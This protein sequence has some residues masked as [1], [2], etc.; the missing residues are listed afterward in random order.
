MK[1][2]YLIAVTLLFGLISFN[3]SYG[4]NITPERA[5][6][7]LSENL[8]ALNLS[9]EDLQN[10]EVRSA[11]TDKLSGVN[12]VYLQQY[13]QGLPVYN[14]LQVIAFKNNK[15]VSSTG[16]R[17]Y[18]IEEAAGAQKAAPALPAKEAVTLAAKAVKLPADIFN[19]QPLTV[20]RQSPDGRITE[21][22][23]STVMRENI[24][25]ELMWVPDDLGNV[26]LG[27]EIKL[28]PFSSS[29][30][31]LV[32][33]DATTGNI[34]G[35][36]NNTIYCNWDTPELIPGAAQKPDNLFLGLSVPSV[37]KLAPA[38]KTAPASAF[39]VNSAQYNVIPFPA[40]S[41]E[42]NGGTISVVTNPWTLAGPGND[43]TTLKWHN[44]GTTEY[45]ITRG[46]NVLARENINNDNNGQPATSSSALPDLSFNFP[47]NPNSSPTG[48][49]N[50]NLAITNL[51]YWNNIMH[52]LT[53][54][55]GFD[56]VAGN[57]QASNM[58]RGAGNPKA[59]ENDYVI[60][61]AQ[62]GSGTNNASFATGVDGVNPTMRMFLW[63]PSPYKTLHINAPS[64]IETDVFAIESNLS[65]NNKLEDV[66]PVTNNLVLYIDDTPEGKSLACA[67]PANA[68]QLNGRIAVIDRG[69]CAFTEKIKNAQNAGAIGVIVINTD[70]TGITMSGD[71]NSITIPAVA[72]L[73]SDGNVLKSIMASYTIN[74]TLKASQDLDG[75]L[76]NGIIAHE[77]AHGISVRLTGGQD[78]ISCLNNQEQMGEGWSDYYSIMITHDWANASVTDGNI[79][80]AVGTY[81]L[82]ENPEDGY[83]IRNYRYTTDMGENPWTYD[84]LEPAHASSPHVVGELWATTLWHMTWNMIEQEGI[85][86]TNLFDATAEGANS[87][88]L[89]LVTLGLKLQP[90]SPG[91]LDGRDAL[92]KADEILFD[93]KYSCAIWDAFAKRGMG[94]DAVQ[95]SSNSLGDQ[96]ADF[97]KPNG[98]LI[99]KTVDKITAP[100]NDILTYTFNIQAQCEPISGFK[101]VDTLAPNV[102]YVSG[103]T[104]NPGNRTVTLN[105]P[106]LNAG[107]SASLTLKVKI[108][109]GTYFVSTNL[110]SETIPTNSMPASLVATTSDETKNWAPHTNNYSAPYSLR[111]TP[112]NVV[113]EQTLTSAN[114]VTISDHVQLSFYHMY[115]FEKQK[116][117]GVVELSLDGGTN[118]IDAGPYMVE[119]G[120]TDKISSASSGINGRMAFTGTRTSFY[121]TTIN[122]SAFQGQSVLFRLRFVTDDA[123][124]SIGWYVDDIYVTRMPAVYNLASVRDA[125][126]KLFSMSDTITAITSA[127][128]PVIWSDF[129]VQK[130]GNR[131][132]LKWETQQESNTD[133]YVVERSAD[134]VNFS[135]IGSKPA[136]GNS[137]TSRSYS[138][139]DESP[140]NGN[141][142]YRIQLLD[143]DGKLSYSKALSLYFNEAANLAVMLTPNPARSN[144]ELTIAENNNLLRIDLVDA[145]GRVLRTYDMK[146]EK[147]NIPVAT[148]AQGVYYLKIKGDKLDTTRKFIK[149]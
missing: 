19:A 71:D 14:A 91:F 59:K 43:A 110:F 13:Y 103:G 104:Y 85:I 62:D 52:D 128:I 29:D 106:S 63:S 102:T 140:M 57:F 60:A 109:T 31:W 58:G 1:K 149:E 82:G 117:G 133:K 10:S 126:D 118:W 77:Y 90:C 98:A 28:V 45:N 21:F 72:I 111:T 50:M 11:H 87:D 42:H 7:F 6:V 20:S 83:G 115:S 69:D 122:L 142:I 148:L 22:G 88:A 120:Y 75:D 139:Y 5:L 41:P 48:S 124:N 92:L 97:T 47:F 35:K 81:V 147:I 112:S 56:E 116:D 12:L 24:T 53:Y 119:N 146:T 54:Q 101:V 96:V 134:G 129:T 108:N 86:N 137:S 80:V 99:K 84:M 141:N 113:A 37:Q 65:L 15:V 49:D 105:V 66:G 2:T 17:L 4:Q 73:N 114:A 78:V 144:I 74:V 16:K 70:N 33:V 23:E 40:M 55:Y 46:N 36:D 61:N 132:L 18:G 32:R 136:A 121:K 25:A 27:W 34:L 67:T 100:Q 95:G 9:K 64:F 3:S 135:A 44:D 76:D 131:A 127:T 125:S 51:F 94:V 143:K 93:G 130:D 107:E 89:K 138:F 145:T 68:A 26:R 123:G 8:E 79:P 30:Y 39:D 38:I